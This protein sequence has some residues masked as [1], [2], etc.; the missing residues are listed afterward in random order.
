MITAAHVARSG[1]LD[2]I[3]MNHCVYLSFFRSLQGLYAGP[4]IRPREKLLF[5]DFVNLADVVLCVAQHAVKAFAGTT[6]DLYVLGLDSVLRP[7][8]KRLI[9]E[10]P[11]ASIAGGVHVRRG[12]N[13]V[14]VEGLVSVLRST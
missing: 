9:D 6:V 12:K 10:V 5:E 3:D 7:D 1:A 13:H 4:A 11:A 8:G 2:S 14:E